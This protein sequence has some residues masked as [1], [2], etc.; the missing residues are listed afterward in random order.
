MSA[1]KRQ[2]ESKLTA[3]Q[4]KA[5]LLLVEREFTPHDERKSLDEIAAECEISV[6][7]LYK[8]RNLNTDFIEYKNIIADDFLSTNRAE[9]Y[10]QL[11]KLIKGSQPSVKAISLFMQRF[12]LLSE[13]KIIE[14]QDTGGGS[15]PDDIA[16]EIAELDELLESSK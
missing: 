9:V 13:R 5:A 7:S 14:T 8:W 11:M 3:M 10:G 1:K 15:S 4:R 2:L 6:R 12:G 16:K